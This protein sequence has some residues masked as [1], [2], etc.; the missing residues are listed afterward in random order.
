MFRQIKSAILWAYI[1][2]FRK[3]LLRLAIIALL[4]F[5]IEYFYAD[6]VEYLRYSHRQNRIFEALIIKWIA[7]AALLGLA[8]FFILQATKKPKGSE[9]KKPSKSLERLDPRKLSKKELRK[10]AQEIIESKIKR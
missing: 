1:W 10:R 8:L 3:L 4:I 6:V 2:R 7:I 5:L 9:A